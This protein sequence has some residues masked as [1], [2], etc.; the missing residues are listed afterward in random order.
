M[1]SRFSAISF[2]AKI[3]LPYIHR[4]TVLSDP[5]GPAAQ[6]G[7]GV[8]KIAFIDLE[9]S[10]L[11]A[12]SWPIEAGWC[13]VGKAPETMLIK[14][15]DS[16]SMAAWDPNAEALHGLSIDA[17]KKSGRTVKEICDALNQALEGAA[18]YSDAPDWDGFWLY[19]L[20]SAA[21]ERMRFTLSDFAD[22]FVDVPQQA[23][24]AAVE[25]ANEAAPHRHRA[26]DDVL[27]MKMIFDLATGVC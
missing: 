8:E 19:R 18:V 23:V 10:G 24:A 7:E 2:C 21:S 3:S 20:F 6:S 25:K 13:F 16:W 1:V 26:R 27:H 12:Q 22:L 11:G 14:P 9:A 4:K 17:I 15:A 5:P